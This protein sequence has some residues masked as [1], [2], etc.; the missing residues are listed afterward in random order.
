[1][2]GV[3]VPGS[4]YWNLGFGRTP[5]EVAD[6]REAAANMLHPG[7]TISWLGA[8]LEGKRERYPVMNNGRS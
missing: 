3:V 5:G 8:A 4:T 6:D 2:N 1:M 7:N